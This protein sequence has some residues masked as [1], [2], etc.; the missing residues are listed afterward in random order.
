MHQIRNGLI[1]LFA[2]VMLSCP[3]ATWSDPAGWP[4]GI[5]NGIDAMKKLPSDGFHVVESQ[6]RVLLMSTNGH[7][8]VVDGKIMD[9]WNGFEIRSVADA[10][11]SLSIPLARMGLGTKEL[12]GVT[13]GKSGGGKPVTLFLD[14]ASPETQKIMPTVRNLFSQYQF[15]VVFV[16]AKA[17]RKKSS[18]ALLCSKDAAKQFITTGQITSEIPSLEQCGTEKLKRNIVTVQVLGIDTLPFTIASNGKT[19]AGVPERYGEFL[20]A[21]M[22]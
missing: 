16:P 1:G 22:E 3:L 8:A 7:Y 13:V 17:T 4:K 11:R 10:E 18:Q 14:P 21:N 19:A 20:A 6:G 2:L 5:L 15:N 9:M 12:S